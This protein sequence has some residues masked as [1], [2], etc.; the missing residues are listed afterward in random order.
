MEVSTILPGLQ[1]IVISSGFVVSLGWLDTGIVKAFFLTSATLSAGSFLNTLSYGIISLTTVEEFL[2]IFFGLLLVGYIQFTG[3]FL[4]SHSQ[5]EYVVHLLWVIFAF[6]TRCTGLMPFVRFCMVILMVMCVQTVHCSFCSHLLMF[7][8]L[9]IFTP[10]LLKIHV[11]LFSTFHDG[12]EKVLT[13]PPF[14]ILLT[15]IWRIRSHLRTSIGSTFSTVF[16]SVS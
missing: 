13:V 8:I 14:F 6:S 12:L 3:N 1:H 2:G 10:L 15:D 16:S 5:W 4:S 11:I 7:W 9:L